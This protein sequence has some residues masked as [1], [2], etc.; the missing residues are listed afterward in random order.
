MRICTSDEIY[1]EKIYFHAFR[2][3]FINNVALLRIILTNTGQIF[4]R[5]RSQDLNHEMTSNFMSTLKI[6]QMQIIKSVNANFTNFSSLL[7]IFKF[8]F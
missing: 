7:K 4:P 8:W 5:F 3:K 6:F 2:W 1:S